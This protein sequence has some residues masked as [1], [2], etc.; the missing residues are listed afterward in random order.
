MVK[1]TRKFNYNKN[2]KKAWRKEKAKKTPKITDA[3]LKE[4]W[5]LTKSIEGNYSEMGL[6]TDA[7]KSLRIPKTKTLLKPEVMDIDQVISLI[8]FSSLKL[9]L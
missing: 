2:L 9:K 3:T 8:L 5:S 1:K 4:A 7:N 6:T